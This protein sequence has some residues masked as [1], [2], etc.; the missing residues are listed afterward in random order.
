MKMIVSSIINTSRV[1]RL[2]GA[3]WGDILGMYRWG[4]LSVCM[5]IVLHGIAPS[6]KEHNMLVN[7]YHA[8]ATLLFSHQ[9]LNEH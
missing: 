6:R 1:W 3:R 9:V 5:V 7:H 4:H 2:V 8:R